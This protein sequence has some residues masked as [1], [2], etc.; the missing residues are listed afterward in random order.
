[1]PVKL[2]VNIMHHKQLPIHFYHVIVA[3]LGQISPET[4]TLF[5]LV[6]CGFVSFYRIFADLPQQHAIK[7]ERSTSKATFCHF[8]C[9]PVST[10]PLATFLSQYL[11]N[12]ITVAKRRLRLLFNL[13][14]HYNVLLHSSVAANYNAVSTCNLLAQRRFGL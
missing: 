10:P 11:A 12:T 1:M 9:L 14:S 3:T 6:I 13:A 5:Q 7:P 4:A 8:S 2:T